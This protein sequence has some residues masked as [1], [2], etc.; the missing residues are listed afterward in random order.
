MRVLHV[1][2][3]TNIGGAGRYLLNL[4]TRPIFKNANLFV[5]CPR[6]ELGDR[7]D[8]LGINRIDISGKDISFSL[9]LIPELMKVIRQVKPDVVHTH[10][11]LSGRIA[12]KFMRIPVVYTKHNLV[13]IPSPTGVKPSPAGYGKRLF[14][15]LTTRMLADK[16]IG[17][18]QG[19]YNEL[20]ESGI[21]RDMVVAIPNG[22]DLSG[23]EPRTKLMEKGLLI[24][25]VARLHPQKALDVFIDAAKL[26]LS[27]EP[28]ARFLI[29]GTGPMEE[30]LKAKIKDMKL[31]PYI[32]M[33]GF[34]EDVPAFLKLLDVYVLSSLYEGLPLATLEAMAAGLPVVA[35][36]VGGVPEAVVDQQTG[37]L[38]PPKQSKLLAQA[39]TRLV[40]DKELARAMGAAGRKRVEEF[41]NAGIMA[42]KTLEVYQ[43]VTGI[44]NMSKN[45]N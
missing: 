44:S 22:I 6:G 29:G 12:S 24:G 30:Q 27:S 9:K 19:V 34:V 37:L 35:T 16:V 13:R 32:K 33:T 14:T 23:F 36:E 10:S 17:V 7:F 15:S 42:R 25:T 40:V 2:T 31:E 45:E 4:L 20:I 11:S 5:A 28:R 39:I 8:K 21:P 1:I 38:V 43:E 3:D 18:S 41:F 26:V